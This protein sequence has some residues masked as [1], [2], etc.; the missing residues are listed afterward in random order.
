MGKS[1]PLT[2]AVVFGGR[3]V[4]HDVSI[5]TGIQACEVLSARHHSVPVY[6][7]RDGHWYAGQGLKDLAVYRDGTYGEYAV[8][9]DVSHGVIV[10]A[11]PPRQRGLR[12]L[13]RGG[14]AEPWRP[15]VVLAATHGTQ[16]EDGCLQGLLELADLP[17]VGPTLE[18]AVLAMNKSVAKQLLRVAGIPVIEDLLLRREAYRAGGGPATVSA[19][20]VGRFGL[21]VYVKPLSLGSSVGVTRASTEQELL[22]GL[23]LAFELDRQVLIEPAVQDAVEVNCAVLGRPGVAPRS[24]ACEQPLS[25]TGFLSFED[26]YLRGS[27]GKGGAKAAG[28]SANGAASATATVPPASGPAAG[29][30][31]AGMA[32]SQRLIPAPI[33]DEQTAKVKDLAERSFTA[34]GCAGVTRVDMLIDSLGHIFVNEC[35]TIPGSFAFYLWEPVGLSFADL[36]DELLKLAQ[37]EHEERLRTTRTFTTNLLA[38]RVAGAAG[39]K[40]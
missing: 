19:E 8:S 12:G 24:S 16:G 36:M 27:G 4:E 26:K 34:L 6:I 5:I 38:S 3:S 18:S 17:Y 13:A 2:V 23:E 25:A 37:D 32:S 39:A 33:G 20:V 11:A 9:F 7:D 22:D 1:A 40:A 15:D 28:S 30:K 29:A 21:P 31:S 14:A 35:N 10:P